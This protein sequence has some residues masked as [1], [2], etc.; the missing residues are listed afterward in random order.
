MTRLESIVKEALI[1]E[2]I[3]ADGWRFKTEIIEK[4]YEF[5]KVAVE[6]YEPHKRNPTT[7]WT[8]PYSTFKNLLFWGEAELVYNRNI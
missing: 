4:G 6:V 8:A 1:A 5:V 3:M 7:I 2:G